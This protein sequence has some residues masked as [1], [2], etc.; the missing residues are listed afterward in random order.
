MSSFISAFLHLEALACRART[1][2]AGGAGEFAD[3]HARAQLLEPLAVALERG[4]QGR[5]LE[6]EGDR[7]RLLQIAAAGHR[8]VAIAP[9]EIG[10][11]GRDLLHVGLDQVERRRGSA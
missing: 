2:C 9:R 11:R 6:A 7:H 10:K 1:R 5:R 3:Q 4:E 8:R